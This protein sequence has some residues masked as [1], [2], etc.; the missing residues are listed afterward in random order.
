MNS[1]AAKM[2]EGS[3]NEWC[4]MGEENVTFYPRKYSFKDELS[5]KL[6]AHLQL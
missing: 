1:M 6:F 5:F 4:L 2:E 3:W